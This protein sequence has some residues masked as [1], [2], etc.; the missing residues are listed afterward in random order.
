MALVEANTAVRESDDT[1]ELEKNDTTMGTRYE[2]A[3]FL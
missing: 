2:I 1:T 3:S